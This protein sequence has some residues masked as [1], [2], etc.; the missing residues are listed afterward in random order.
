[1]ADVFFVYP[2]KLSIKLL[3][4]APSYS[5][6]LCVY[7]VNLVLNATFIYFFRD[8]RLLEIQTI[9]PTWQKKN[10]RRE[11]QNLIGMH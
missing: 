1:M 6:G 9:K 8:Y 4:F 3:I 5:R 10:K 11:L 7:V 2:T